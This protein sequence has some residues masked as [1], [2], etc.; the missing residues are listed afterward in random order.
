MYR[1][2]DWLYGCG[3]VLQLWP[4]SLSVEGCDE[5]SVLRRVYFEAK[6]RE[7]TRH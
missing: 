4:G 2:G 7:T 6:C 1:I 5:K 3:G